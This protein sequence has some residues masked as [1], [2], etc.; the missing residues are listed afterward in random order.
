MQKCKKDEAKTVPSDEIIDTQASDK[1]A[2]A[3]VFLAYFLC[4]SIWGTT[5]YAIRVCIAPG[6]FPTYP[7]AALRFTLSALLLAAYWLIQMK[8][9]KP[10]SA[11]E[12]RWIFCAG[13]T[14]GIAYGLLYS[15]EEQISG[16]LAAVL[17]ATGPLIA[18]M[19]AMAT[20]TEGTSRI[21]IFGSIFAI[22]GVALVFH[23]RLQ[24][25][26]AQASAVGIVTLVCV[27]NACSNVMM[28]RHAKAV[29]AIACNTIFFAAA[30]A[31]LWIAAAISGKYSITQWNPLPTAALL[32]LTVFGTLIAFAAFFYLLKH[33]RL[34]TAMTLAFVT[35]IIA[36]A[37]DAVFEKGTVF[38]AETYLGIA[39]VLISV[40]MSILVK[41]RPQS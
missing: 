26:V 12:L 38:T 3:K 4:A 1:T 41:D 21:K 29:G 2:S 18:A 39:I 40:A 36:L 37:V 31:T 13:G 20:K 35:P 7:A 24:V 8:K 17:S 32:Y 33:V 11:Q 6:G 23:D 28:K 19:L 9:L 25:S 15:A 30:S 22:A 16:G 10:P 14:S 27:L 5:W 34:S